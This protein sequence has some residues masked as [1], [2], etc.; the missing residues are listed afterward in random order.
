MDRGE[1]LQAGG[2]KNI[3]QLAFRQLLQ[4][5]R[6]GEIGFL[7]TFSGAKREGEKVQ[8]QG[9]QKHAVCGEEG[10]TGKNGKGAGRAKPDGGAQKGGIEENA[11]YFERQVD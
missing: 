4:K 11:G 7:S 6:R 10:E 1:Q 3:D 2:Q 8:V 5:N 9:G